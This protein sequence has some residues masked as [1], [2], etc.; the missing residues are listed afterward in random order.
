VRAAGEHADLRDSEVVEFP[1]PQRRNPFAGSHL[2]AVAES[3]RNDEIRTE[4]SLVQ[5]KTATRKNFRGHASS[6]AALVDAMLIDA[7]GQ[8]RKSATTASDALVSGL[9]AELRHGNRAAIAEFKRAIARDSELADANIAM[10]RV[11]LEQG[12]WKQAFERVD[13]LMSQASLSEHQ[14]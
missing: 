14:R 10:A 9:V 7:L 12:R 3:D 1:K 11:L 2:Q 13:P 5:G 6:L 4:L 8:S